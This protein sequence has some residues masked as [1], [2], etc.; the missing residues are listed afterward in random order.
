[1]SFE[2]IEH[3]YESI[4]GFL[5]EEDELYPSEFEK[6]SHLLK[7]LED[8]FAAKCKII[9]SCPDFEKELCIIT[10]GYEEIMRA[11]CIKMSQYMLKKE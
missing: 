9:E 2:D 10:D 7:I 11:L 4:N 8:I 1:M 3:I 5:E 6:G